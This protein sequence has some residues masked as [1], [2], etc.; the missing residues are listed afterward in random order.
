MKGF[1]YPVLSTLPVKMEYFTAIPNSDFT[2]A[3]LKWATSVEK[4]TNYLQQV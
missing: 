4:N 1:V 2:R 3:E